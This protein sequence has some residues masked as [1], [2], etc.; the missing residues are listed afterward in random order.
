[1]INRACGEVSRTSIPEG[2][3]EVCPAAGFGTVLALGARGTRGTNC[4]GAATMT[5][6]S[7][8]YAV[9]AGNGSRGTGSLA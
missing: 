3:T 7:P 8:S 6:G 5:R 2:T 9:G 1:M 4:P